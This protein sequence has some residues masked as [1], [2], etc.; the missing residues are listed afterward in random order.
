LSNS[1]DDLRAKVEESGNDV[2]L[3]VQFGIALAEECCYEEAAR[4]FEKAVELA[5]LRAEGHYNLGVLYGKF[6]LDDIAVDEM[7]EDHTDEEAYF[8]KASSSYQKALSIDPKMTAALNNLARLSDA[9]GMHDEARKYFEESLAINA[10]QPDVVEDL[11]EL[12]DRDDCDA[13]EDVTDEEL[14]GDD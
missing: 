14:L 12:F 11:A 7:W 9:M 4:Q 1:I 6:L 8:S 10:N 2:D 13:A 3:R 5:P